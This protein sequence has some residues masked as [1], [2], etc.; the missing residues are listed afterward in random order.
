MAS[1]KEIIRRYAQQAGIPGARM[2]RDSHANV[3]VGDSSWNSTT[4]YSFGEHF[5]MAVLRPGADGS[6]RG[7]WLVNGDRYSK[8]TTPHQAITRDELKATG[9]P[10]MI[11]PFTALNMAG[12]EQDTITPVDIL[13]DRYTAEP[14]KWVPKEGQETP[15]YWYDNVR[16]IDGTWWHDT[17]V[18]HLG[19]SL[20]TA[21]ARLPGS[22]FLREPAFT[23]SYLSSFD[24]NEPAGGLYFLA[25]LPGNPATVA[26][27]VESL[28]PQAVKDAE[29]KGLEVLRQGDVFAIPTALLTRDMPG[30]GER[31]AYV[32]G[33][34]HVATEVRTDQ[35]QTYA[36]GYLRH[37]PRESWR[38]PEHRALKLG[39]GKTWYELVKNTVAD[40]RSWSVTGRVD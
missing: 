15:P 23:R 35:S 32:L 37:R 26:E 30:P 19:S 31:S 18:H 1:T 27:A 33:V 4:L 25:E 24:E 7:W 28:K 2:L 36:R 17:K 21:D 16:E 20:F 10:I 13:P 3:F 9:L 12:I 6:P 22:A 34:N 39:D 5:P 8:S 29:D 38:E 11:I 40:G 14:R